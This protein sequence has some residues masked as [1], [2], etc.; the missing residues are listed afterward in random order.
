MDLEHA[1]HRRAARICLHIYPLLLLLL[2]PLIEQPTR[3]AAF[4]LP[5]ISHPSA[6]SLLPHV[7][8]CPRGSPSYSAGSSQVSLCR[9][10]WLTWTRPHLHASPPGGV[11]AS[12]STATRWVAQC[13]ISELGLPMRTSATG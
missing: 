11:A 7:C 3:F 6:V 5:D 13:S 8:F 2:Q 1:I 4:N 9:A 10:G 12:V